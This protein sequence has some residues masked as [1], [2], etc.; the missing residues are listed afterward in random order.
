MCSQVENAMVKQYIMLTTV[1]AYTLP[2]TKKS[3]LTLRWVLLVFG[4]LANG[5]MICVLPSWRSQIEMAILKR[6]G[7]SAAA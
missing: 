4:T 5:G 2:I 1:N 6:D 7:L 3:A